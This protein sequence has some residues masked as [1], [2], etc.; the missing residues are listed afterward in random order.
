MDERD[1]LE[2][3]AGLE[4]ARSWLAAHGGA[5]GPELGADQG[6]GHCEEC[7]QLAGARFVLGAFVLCL[8]CVM[9]R[10]RAGVMAGVELE[11]P[12]VLPHPTE[13]CPWLGEEPPP[14]VGEEGGQEGPG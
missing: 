8:R 14:W 10:R 11:A 7:S 9:R 12:A 13:L 5:V 3:A 6:A 2:V 4:L 1:P